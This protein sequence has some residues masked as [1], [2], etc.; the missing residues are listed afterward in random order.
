MGI[1]II[2]GD[3]LKDFNGKFDVESFD[4]NFYVHV[5][6]IDNAGNISETATKEYEYLNI[7]DIEPEMES[8]SKDNMIWADVILN[9]ISEDNKA[10]AIH[11]VEDI[12]SQEITIHYDKTKLKYNGSC[13][14][15]RAFMILNENE[16]E[17]LITFNLVCRNIN[18]Y[19]GKAN[20][21]AL[22]FDALDYGESYLEVS[23]G[24]VKDV[25]NRDINVLPV[26]LGKCSI[27]VE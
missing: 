1:K 6:A 4:H 21:L 2:E 22:S 14:C 26:Q 19:S 27:K 16:D 24:I 18:N 13:T 23:S 9:N 25:N 12:A 15:D 10:F 20:M 8:A 7:L 3:E 17:G 5:A 11:D